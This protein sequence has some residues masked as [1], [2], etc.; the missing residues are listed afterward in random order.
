M[1]TVLMRVLPVLIGYLLGSFLPAY[2]L[3]LW[4]RKVDIRT[5]GDGN[6]GTINT[7]NTM[8]PALGLLVALYDVSK[9]LVAMLIAWGWFKAPTFIVMLA[10]FAAILGHKYPFYLH[11]KGGRG[12]AATVGIFV[13]LLGKTSVDAMSTEELALALAFLLTYAALIMAATHDGDFLATTLLPTVGAILAFYVHSYSEL[14]LVLLLI[15]MIAYESIKNLRRDMFVLAPDRPTLW[16][17]FA[18]SLAILVVILGLFISRQT[19]LIVAGSALAALLVLEL[20]R[21]VIPGLERA[22]HRH[23]LGNVMFL[24]EEERGRMSSLTVFLFGLFLPLAFLPQGVAYASLAFLSVGGMMARIVDL[25]FGKTPL[26]STK[27]STVQGS[28]AFLAASLI[29]AYFFWISHTLPLPVGLVGACAATL[30]QLT[31][32]WAN[33]NLSVPLVSGAVMQA[34]LRLLP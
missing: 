3:P 30:A 8:G 31:S 25:N 33:D 12:I 21:V 5:M 26:P 4:T 17:I 16:R 27:G 28:T 11:F 18:R 13:Y 23:I 15:A 29:I 32:R 20:L 6:P 19:I 2:F 1:L 24:R 9:G 34:V 10:G 7:K 22:L 14:T